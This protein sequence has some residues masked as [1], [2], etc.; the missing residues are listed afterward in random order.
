M[1][2]V[3]LAGSERHM[4]LQWHGQLCWG[5][6]RAAQQETRDPARA[7]EQQQA[8]VQ[9][10]AQVMVLVCCRASVVTADKHTSDHT[11]TQP[12]AKHSRHFLPWC[13]Y[14]QS[15]CTTLAPQAVSKTCYRCIPDLW[16]HDPLD[17]CMRPDRVRHATD[18]TALHDATS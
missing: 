11:S 6:C 9:A 12:F 7:K 5:G 18:T 1:L 10:M 4:R 13:N 15:S 3:T 16:L 8:P 17:E 14:Q 2:V